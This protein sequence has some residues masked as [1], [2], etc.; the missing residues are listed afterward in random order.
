MVT[1]LWVSARFAHTVGR[2]QLKD[3]CNS[4]QKHLPQ[5]REK[6]GYTWQIGPKSLFFFF[7]EVHHE[8]QKGVLTY[9]SIQ[10]IRDRSNQNVNMRGHVLS[11]S[12]IKCLGL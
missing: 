10:L 11:K 6:G 12:K 5:G 9:Y 2:S 7:S 3:P 4:Y 1:D 8:A